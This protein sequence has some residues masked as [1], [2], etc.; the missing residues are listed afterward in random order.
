LIEARENVRRHTWQPPTPIAL[1][2]LLKQKT[3]ETNLP[4]QTYSET[5]TH[6]HSMDQQPSSPRFDVLL[7]TVNDHEYDAVFSLARER[8][9]DDPTPI[10]LRRTYYDL[11]EI[12]GIRV[13]LVRSEM[14]SGQP[15][16]AAT[17]TLQAMH[18][19]QP[20]YIIAVGIMFGIDPD[21]QKIGHVL[22]SRQIQ[23]YNLMKIA[24]DE[25]TGD[26]KVT[27]RGDKVTA[28]P[29]FL[30]RVRDAADH[31]QEGR[32]E[33]KPEAAL[34]LSGDK[35]VDNVDFRDQLLGL[36]PEAKGGEMEASGIYS[37]ARE[38]EIPW[39]VI[40]AICDHADGE[41]SK[42]KEERQKIAAGKAARFV[43]YL[44]ERGGLIQ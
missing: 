2:N 30:N 8:L 15:G 9:G 34:I 17:T 29:R 10:Y 19:L 37:A 41:K 44:L 6:E 38:D 25:R 5:N 21:K 22:Y 1:L 13:A 16:G 39:M 35:L 3:S 43:F 27:P 20:R 28:N 40:K 42:D 4:S 36:F 23:D 11:G 32:D 24:T 33:G 12:G 18:D 7:V 31:W 14:G 26:F